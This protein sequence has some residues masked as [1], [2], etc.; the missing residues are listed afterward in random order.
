MKTL[1]KLIVF[2]VGALVLML[3]MEVKHRMDYTIKSNR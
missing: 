2:I 1:S 3:G